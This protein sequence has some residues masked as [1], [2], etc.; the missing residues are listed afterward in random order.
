[1]EYNSAIKNK[2]QK[3]NQTKPKQKKPYIMICSQM[4]GTRKDHSE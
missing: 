2:K 4:D 1:M 3:P